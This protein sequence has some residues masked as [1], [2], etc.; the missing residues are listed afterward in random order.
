MKQASTLFWTWSNVVSMVRAVMTIPIVVALLG[1]DHTTA[2]VLCLAAAATDWLDG[3]VA[4]WTGTV[5][6]WGKVLDPIADK[7]LVG[8]VVVVLVM[9]D[10]LPWWF[11]ASVLAR[12]IIIIIGGLLARRYTPVVLPSLWSGKIAVSFIA[13]TGVVAMTPWSTAR[14]ILMLPSGIAMLVSL[15]DYGRRYRTLVRTGDVELPSRTD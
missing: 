6:E 7:I 12:D 5:S 15:Y 11:V 10:R 8:A 1:N 4:R 9:T 14:D 2:V 13:L 3:Q